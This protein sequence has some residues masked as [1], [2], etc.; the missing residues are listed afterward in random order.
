MRPRSVTALFQTVAR[1]WLTLALLSLTL[2]ADVRSGLWLPL[3]LTLAGAVATAISGAMQ[4]FVVA[5]TATPGPATWLVWTRFGVLSA[6]VAIMALGVTTQTRLMVAVGGSAFLVSMVLLGSLVLGAWRRSLLKRHGAL[7][8]GYGAAVAFVLLGGAI[9]ALIGSGVA[10]GANLAAAARTHVMLNLLGFVSM[11]VLST[12]VTFLP[13][14]LRVRMPARRAG[15]A[16]ASAGAG[17]VLLATG[18]AADATVLFAAGAW[19]FAAGAV[20]AC[21]LAVAALRRERSFAI[22]AAALHVGA[23]L[24]WFVG[25][26]IGLAWI[27]LDGPHALDA[28]RPW[29]LV[30][31]VTGWAVQ[32]LVGAWTYLLPMALGGHPDERRRWLAVGEV[33]GR[34]QVVV[35]NAGLLFVVL[36]NLGVVGPGFR[37]A[38]VVA[39]TGAATV[40]LVRVWAF[41]AMSRSRLV[42]SARAVGVW[43]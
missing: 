29:F 17:V 37:T 38:G 36:G 42:R 25:G 11:T 4:N 6:G 21:S 23:G 39:A 13:T 30:V 35:A 18:A 8:A 43:G 12:L 40:A 27:A 20:L 5:M 14:L 41:R 19:L 34:T 1:A 31:F 28:A 7:I 16:L 33:G 9:G 24:G 2:P 32:I 22:P 15:P 3:H 26:S 10:D